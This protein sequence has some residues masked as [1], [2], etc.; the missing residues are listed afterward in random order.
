MNKSLIAKTMNKLEEDCNEYKQ[1]KL[2]K[3]ELEKE[4]K[5]LEKEIK[6]S[7]EEIKESEVF[8]TSHHIK[9]SEV[10]RESLNT[11]KLKEERPMLF[12]QYKKTS[13]YHRL[14]VK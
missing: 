9:L 2:L 7:L 5:V 3:S 12:E 1:L 4:I 11:K 6:E 8:T 10:A 14:L 13:I